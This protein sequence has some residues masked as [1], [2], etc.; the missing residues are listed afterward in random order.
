ME[1]VP[2]G[3]R[4]FVHEDGITYIGVGNASSEIAERIGWTQ[5][6]VWMPEHVYTYALTKRSRIFP[7]P[8]L[9]ASSI[10]THPD[11]VHRA[12][13][14]NDAWY[15][16]TSGTALRDRRVLTSESTR[17]VDAAIELRHVSGGSVLRLFHLSPR[18]RNYGGE[19]LWP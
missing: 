19:K 12:V 16:I 5:V 14:R 11:S 8:A 10:L 18:N 17:Y 9:L 15:F 3:T 6:N 7:K 13:R 2:V 1:L 4:V